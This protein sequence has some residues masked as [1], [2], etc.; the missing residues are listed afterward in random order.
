MPV[1]NVRFSIITPSYNQGMY[2]EETIKSILSQEGTFFID[3]II[4]DGGSRDNS[5]EV[6]KKYESLLQRGAWPVG[7]RGIRYRWISERDEGQAHAINKGLAMSDGDILAWLNSDD[8]YAP[9]ALQKVS[10]TFAVTP[11]CDVLYGEASY[12]DES[13]RTI[14]RY[15]TEPFSFKRL[16]QFNFISQ[17]STFFR[18]TAVELVGHLDDSLHYSM[19]Y[20]LWIRMAGKCHFLFL[21]ESLATYR[22]HEA[23]K[24]VS[25]RHALESSRECLDVVRHYYH[26][27][28]IN[29]VYFY[30][31]QRYLANMPSLLLKSKPL[32]I[33]AAIISASVMYCVMNRGIRR[34]DV[35]YSIKNIKKVFHDQHSHRQ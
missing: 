29:R 34:E 20:E 4:V 5:I 3:Y 14:G 32:A 12:I 6:I 19:D 1:D 18:K 22:L 16:A 31:Y 11:D 9:G 10:E 17:P 21:E 35:A 27:A 7:C 30:Y 26:W 2:L 15:P 25:A 8:T 33:V 13:G 23:S 28:P 24:T